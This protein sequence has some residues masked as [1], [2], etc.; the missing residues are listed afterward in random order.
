MSKVKIALQVISYSYLLKELDGVPQTPAPTVSSFAAQSG[1][2]YW[3]EEGADG[4]P[5][6]CTEKDEAAPQITAVV[7]D[8]T[9]DFPLTSV[10]FEVCTAEN[11]C[12]DNFVG[13]RP[14]RY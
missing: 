9:D 6:L 14:P 13:T 12:E 7:S 8:G 4:K 10:D 1:G 2:V 3:L 5:N 11:P